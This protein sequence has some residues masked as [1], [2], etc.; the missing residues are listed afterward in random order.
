MFAYGPWYIYN[1]VDR[2]FLQWWRK[3]SGLVLEDPTHGSLRQ[4]FFNQPSLWVET[5]L[6]L[7]ILY[8]RAGPSDRSMNTMND[9]REH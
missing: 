2:F 9:A 1:S 4:G 8:V 5:V 7:C 6:T 3:N